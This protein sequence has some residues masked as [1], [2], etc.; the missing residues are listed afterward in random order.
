[1]IPETDLK[2]RRKRRTNAHLVKLHI[3]QGKRPPL[4]ED[5]ELSE[6][7]LP[8]E[9]H[10][11]VAQKPLPVVLNLSNV[12][13]K[14]V[15][16]KQS[17]PTIQLKF[18]KRKLSPESDLCD[19]FVKIIL[20]LSNTP[21][22][23]GFVHPVSTVVVPDYLNII[24]NPLCLEDMKMKCKDSVYKSQEEFI[25]DIKRIT[26]NCLLYNG[27]V[28]PLTAVA[29]RMFD[30]V[31]VLLGYEREKVEKLEATLRESKDKENSVEKKVDAVI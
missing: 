10:V 29:G 3:K 20:K 24:K 6:S 1:M 17:F 21:E 5:E 27:P 12:K 28:H 11:G 4:P 30:N 16:E 19:I 13:R 18:S 23:M 8:N 7:E 15:E 22:Y 9:G 2:S 31:G 26:D 25:V 14:K